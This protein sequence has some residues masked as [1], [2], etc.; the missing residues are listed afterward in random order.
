MNWRTSCRVAAALVVVSLGTATA[1]AAQAA[2]GAAAASPTPAAAT[3]DSAQAALTRRLFELMRVGP[4]VLAEMESGVEAQRKASAASANLPEA[5]WT[6]FSTRMRR[7]LPQ[8]VETLVPIYATRFSRQELEQLVA[9]YRSPLGRHLTE[10]SGAIKV[11]MM[12]AGYRWGVAL[13]ADVAKELAD[14]G[15]MLQ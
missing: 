9:F 6:E 10:V 12:Q 14:K 4:T 3:V 8:F 2:A 11:E 13:G 7:D 5:F 15:V 1:A